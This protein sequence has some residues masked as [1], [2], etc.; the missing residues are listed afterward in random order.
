[1]EAIKRDTEIAGMRRAYLRDSA[2]FVRLLAW[3][4]DKLSQGYEISEYEA[5]FRLTEYRRTDKH[6]GVS[7]ARQF[8]RP[9]QT[10]L[11]LA[12]HPAN[13]SLP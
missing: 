11:S 10:P 13:N 2:S 5:A 9:V 12:I 3:L 4:E 1:M 6:L 8:P 7:L